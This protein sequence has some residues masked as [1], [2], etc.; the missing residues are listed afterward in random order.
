MAQNLEVD[1]A[2]GMRQ[3][4]RSPQQA[5]REAL[6]SSSPS[7]SGSHVGI[8]HRTSIPSWDVQSGLCGWDVGFKGKL[9]CVGADGWPRDS[10][11]ESPTVGV[12]I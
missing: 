6:N 1:D 10:C 5:K 12:V 7:P 3:T 11:H 9:Y 4:R 8:P 2:A